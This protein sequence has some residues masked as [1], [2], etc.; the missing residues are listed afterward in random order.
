MRLFGP[1]FAAL[2]LCSCPARPELV[3]FHSEG[4]SP[5]LS[6]VAAELGRANPPLR[7]RLEPSDSMLAVRKI[8]EL[9]QVADVVA[10]TDAALL[11]PLGDTTAPTIF[12]TDEVVLAHKDHS[13]FTDEISTRNWAE[14]I[15]RPGV[16]IACASPDTSEAGVH[17]Q[18]AWQLAG[19]YETRGRC[20]GE[21]TVSG[22]TELVAVLEARG[23]DYVFLHRSTASRHHLKVTALPPEWNLSRP[24][25]DAAYAIA[26]V[27]ARG[28]DFAG[29]AISCGLIAASPRNPAGVQRLLAALTSPS[30]RRALER[31]GFRPVLTPGTIT[32]R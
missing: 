15:D 8:T 7:V 4:L 6:D 23:A 30:G 29:K 14:V 5:V 17:A 26:S 11:A 13:R 24:D 18:L 31:A 20:R 28:R 21:N 10:V 32:G 3:V 16:R 2:A 12:A 1:L 19:Q 9:G 25:L 27:R 22:E